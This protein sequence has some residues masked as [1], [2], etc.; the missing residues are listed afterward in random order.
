M[1]APEGVDETIHKATEDVVNVFHASRMSGFFNQHG[2]EV[3]LHKFAA[4]I[5]EVAKKERNTP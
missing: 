4:A 3:A 2:L 5:L 1:K